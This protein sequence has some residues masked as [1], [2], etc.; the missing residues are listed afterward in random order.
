MS[1]V[2]PEAVA[3]LAPTGVLRVALNLGNPNLVKQAPSGSVS[4]LAVDLAN[5]LARRVSLPLETI[6]FPGA[7]RV[8]E[9]VSANVWDLSFLA[10]DPVRANEILFTSPYVMLSGSYVVRD[11]SGFKVND[12]VDRQ[13]VR[14]VVGKGSA[15]DLYLSKAIEQASLVRV[16]TTA[17]VLPAMVREG[18][19]V[20]AGVRQQLREQVLGL[21][22]LGLLEGRFMTIS[23]AAAVPKGRTS[24][25]ALLQE[26]IEE[27]KASGFVQ[28]SLLRHD[29]KGVE[30]PVPA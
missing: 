9:A 21:P 27:M 20:A 13:G 25:F 5:E 7:G 6:C 22:G 15:Y 8:V 11:D 17:E 14:I 24:G 26:F 18:Y 19:E 23:Q 1:V 28:S 29:V 4:G 2:D 10:V 16:P 12:D 30:F 3:D